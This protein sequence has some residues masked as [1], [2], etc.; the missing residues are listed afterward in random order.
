M[1]KK[2]DLTESI[3]K[4]LKETGSKPKR[5][6]KYGNRWVTVDDIKFQSKKE[7]N[8]YLKLKADKAAGRIKEFTRQQR[9]NIAVNDIKI[10]AYVADFVVTHHGGRVEVIDVKSE[11][12]AKL[13]AYRLKKKLLFATLGITI[14]EK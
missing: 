12:T 11:A 5:R 3:L 9:F 14:V 8:Y 10:C 7:A 1:R 6:N 2:T 13:P 4:A